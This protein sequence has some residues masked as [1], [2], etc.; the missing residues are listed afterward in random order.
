MI[1][2]R[3]LLDAINLQLVSLGHGWAVHRDALPEQ[4][5]R[6][7]W[8]ISAEEQERTVMTRFSDDV[9][10]KIN[11]LCIGNLNE[12][13]KGNADELTAMADEVIELFTNAS[14]VKVNDR[15]I[16]IVGM[17]AERTAEDGFKIE[18][19]LFFLDSARTSKELPLIEKVFTNQQV[20]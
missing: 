20:K 14:Y 15:C 8:F 10:Q 3:M 9:K 18:M 11:I 7:C 13:N 4:F 2:Q 19:K 1:T 6:P 5:E 17:K 16:G 12:D